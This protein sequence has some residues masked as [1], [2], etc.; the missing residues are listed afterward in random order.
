[1]NSFAITLAIELPVA[2]GDRLICVRLPISIVTAIVST[3]G[4]PQGE[5]TARQ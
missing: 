5:K 4:S 3:Y 2:N 1:M